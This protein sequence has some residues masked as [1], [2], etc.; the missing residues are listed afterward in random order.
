MI[1][2]LGQTPKIST[3]I[4]I[5]VAPGTEVDRFLEVA[6]NIWPF[7]K[8]TEHVRKTISN[9]EKR[10][11]KFSFTSPTTSKEHTILLD[12]LFEDNPYTTTVEKSIENELLLTEFPQIHVHLPNINCILA[13][14]LT[15]FA[16]NT[17]GIPYN[18]DK[19]LE[20]IKQLYDIASLINEIDDFHEVTANYFRIAES[21]LLYRGIDAKPEDA[22]NDTLKTSICIAGRGQYFPD[23]Y[24]VLK[25]GISGLR[26]HIFSENFSGEIAVQRAC[27]VMYIA[28]AVLTNKSKLPELK[29]DHFYLNTKLKT[30]E[31]I[32]LESIRKTDMPAY[33][34][35]VE[36]FEMMA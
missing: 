16:P 22:L 13:D 10:H 27:M 7:I 17:T 33:K 6:A 21:E 34:Y 25:K 30:S 24:L 36:A 9:I 29:D 23:D 35:L 14:K 20:I 18:V 28:A 15:A 1:N 26:N 11:F 5:V 8:T 31:Y 3:D 12:I 19:E 32:K 4:D 2:P